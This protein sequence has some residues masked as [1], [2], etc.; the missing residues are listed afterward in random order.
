MKHILESEDLQGEALSYIE[1][2]YGK[3]VAWAFPS[4]PAELISKLLSGFTEA[5][6]DEHLLVHFGLTKPSP[7]KPKKKR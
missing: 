2:T 6:I 3:D 4:L 7:V 1:T 5:M